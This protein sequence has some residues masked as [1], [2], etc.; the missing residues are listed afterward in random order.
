MR[1]L[2]KEELLGEIFSRDAAPLPKLRRRKTFA[3]PL[4][5]TIVVVFLPQPDAMRQLLRSNNSVQEADSS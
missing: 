1:W 5:Q 2:W 4:G 3:K